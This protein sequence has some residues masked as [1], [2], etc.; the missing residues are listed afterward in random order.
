MNNKILT[1]HG[2]FQRHFELCKT[3]RTQQDAYEQLE[4]EL[5]QLHE[6]WGVDYKPRYSSYESFRMNKTR[7]YKM[8]RE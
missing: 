2:Y 3:C 5:K 1:L 7:Y 6:A 4:D 8:Y